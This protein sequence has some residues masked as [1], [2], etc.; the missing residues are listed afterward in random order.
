MTCFRLEFVQPEITR[1]YVCAHRPKLQ[2]VVCVCVCARPS[3]YCTWGS[4]SLCLGLFNTEP[5]C[6]PP[7][8]PAVAPRPN[9]EAFEGNLL[10]L[11]NHVQWCPGFR[12]GGCFD[13]PM[14]SARA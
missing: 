1:V 4:L 6:A 14:Q 8:L 9:L 2:P 13:N 11:V 12:G 7:R 3:V 10:L 5:H